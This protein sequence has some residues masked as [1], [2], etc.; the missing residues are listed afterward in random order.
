MADIHELTE[1]IKRKALELGFARV[2]ITTADPFEGYEDELCRRQGY[3]LWQPDDPS[4]PLRRA[5]HP[6]LVV[7][8]A[9]SIISLVRA[10]DV[11]DY[12]EELLKHVGRIYLA[13]CYVPPADTLEGWRV[14]L[15]EEYLK[16]LGITSLYDHTN[17]QLVDRALAA[18]AGVI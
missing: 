4:S 7:P 13:R 17:M 9:K 2:G 8:E 15:F 6:E 11:I 16:S 18:R 10:V 1:Q 14:T 12:P 5:A 3:D